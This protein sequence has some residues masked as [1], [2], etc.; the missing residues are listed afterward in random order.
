[1]R[2]QRANTAPVASGT[3]G[4]TRRSGMDPSASAGS[5]RKS[6]PR[7]SPRDTCEARQ[8]GTSAP[9]VRAILATRSSAGS[10]S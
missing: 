4:L 3:R 8:A 9:S 1:M 2:S 7:P 5:G 6:S 10:T